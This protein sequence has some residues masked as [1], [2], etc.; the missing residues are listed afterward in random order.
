MHC[1]MCVTPCAPVHAHCYAFHASF[2][3]CQQCYRARARTIHC[4]RLRTSFCGNA[5]LR[6]TSS[7]V[8]ANKTTAN[9]GRADDQGVYPQ[10]ALTPIAPTLRRWPFGTTSRHPRTTQSHPQTTSPVIR[11]RPCGHPHA[12][13]LRTILMQTTSG[14]SLWQKTLSKQTPLK[15]FTTKGPPRTWSETPRTSPANT[16]RWRSA[17]LQFGKLS[18]P[19]SLWS[20]EPRKQTVSSGAT[21]STTGAS[22]AYVAWG[23]SKTGAVTNLGGR[24]EALRLSC[25]VPQVALFRR[26]HA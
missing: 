25:L 18:A 2:V 10:P 8:Y 9:Q 6:P 3:R 16:W 14:P 19:L 4:L 13:D 17:L 22:S 15:H 1:V 5:R 23:A 26:E 12:D 20:Q 21:Y 24:E 7:V 11:R